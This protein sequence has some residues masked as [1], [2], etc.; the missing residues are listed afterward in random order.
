MIREV[1]EIYNNKEVLR[2]MLGACIHTSIA[3][4]YQDNLE[5]RWAKSPKNVRMSRQFLKLVAIHYRTERGISFYAKE[6][7][8]SKENLCRN[9]KS[10]TNMT[11]L[12][13]IDYLIIIDAKTQL[14]STSATI[15]EIGISLGF[16]N[17]ATFCRFFRR[18]TGVSPLKYRD[19]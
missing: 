4:Y 14:K 1:P 9:I 8:T 18:H 13:V 6:L 3:M 15:K 19:K 2:S 11:A 10:C 5:E 17:L 12:D 16:D 7:G